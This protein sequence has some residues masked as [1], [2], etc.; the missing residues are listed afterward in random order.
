MKNSK[1][2][3]VFH[4]P[5]ILPQ[6]RWRQ[7]RAVWVAVSAIRWDHIFGPNIMKNIFQ[8]NMS[9]GTIVSF[10]E[11]FTHVMSK[12]E[13]F[14]K[15][16]RFPWT[17]TFPAVSLT[18]AFWVAVSAISWNHNFAPLMLKTDFW[19]KWAR[20]PN[21][22]FRSSLHIQQSNLKIF[23]TLGVFHNPYFLPQIHRR[24]SKPW[25][26]SAS[27]VLSTI[28]LSSYVFFNESNTVRDRKTKFFARHS[29]FMGEK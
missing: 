20:G 5:L 15:P 7:W 23:N 16:G 4:K 19:R 22:Y 9:S 27:L 1:N 11:T 12:F 14:Q 24:H 25:P 6:Y 3:G 8:T 2:Q 13:K 26:G 29:E 18:R 17:F 21:T 28:V 10:S